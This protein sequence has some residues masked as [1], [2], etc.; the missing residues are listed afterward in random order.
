MK[1]YILLTLIFLGSI[2]CRQSVD[3][4]N[5][6]DVAKSFLNGKTF[7]A[8]V[9]KES[10]LI[11]FQNGQVSNI[12]PGYS[13]YRIAFAQDGITVKLTEYTREVF[14]G[15]WDISLFNGNSYKLRLYELKPEPTSTSG[16]LEFEI[17]KIDGETLEYR[18]VRSSP[19][20]GDTINEY[21]LIKI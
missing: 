17:S 6:L 14:E 5:P 11:V 8:N 3:E 19:K 4:P 10:N 1:N 21:K 12:I 2:S 15:K 18:S 20:T 16:I 7:K 9:V 13:Q